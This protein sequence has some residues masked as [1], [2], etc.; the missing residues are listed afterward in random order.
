MG[1]PVQRPGGWGGSAHY[2]DPTAQSAA[3]RERR[4]RRR[5]RVVRGSFPGLA[6]PFGLSEVQKI[7]SFFGRLFVGEDGEIGCGNRLRRCGRRLRAG[8]QPPPMAEL[9]EARVGA[10]TGPVPL[11]GHITSQPTGGRG[12]HSRS[13]VAFGSRKRHRHSRICD[14]PAQS[15]RPL[16]CRRC[17]SA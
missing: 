5:A 16:L 11:R 7:L 14:T 4:R 12:R 2:P 6:G 3:P 1:P 8:P 13:D 17:S 10:L 15:C 9:C